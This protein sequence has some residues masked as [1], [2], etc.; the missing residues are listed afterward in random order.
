MAMAMEIATIE[1]SEVA[2][3]YER[4][5]SGGGVAEQDPYRTHN[6]DR[7]TVRWQDVEAAAYGCRGGGGLG[8]SLVCIYASA[9][10]RGNAHVVLTCG[11]LQRGKGREASFCP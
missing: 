7:A 3:A 6:R 5:S 11:F 10:D 2:V 8:A 1:R 9:T 4:G